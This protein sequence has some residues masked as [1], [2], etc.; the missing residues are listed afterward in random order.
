M[1]REA[2]VPGASHR[3]LTHCPNPLK[4]YKTFRESVHFSGERVPNPLNSPTQLRTTHKGVMLLPV[5]CQQELL[6]WSTLYPAGLLCGPVPMAASL[7]A[8]PWSQAPRADQGSPQVPEIQGGLSLLQDPAA[9]KVPWSH[10][11]QAH[12]ACQ[13]FPSPLPGPSALKVPG[14][15]A[16]TGSHSPALPSAVKSTSRCL[17]NLL[18]SSAPYLAPGVSLWTVHRILTGCP[19]SLPPKQSF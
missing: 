19:M 9:Q 10:S 1:G 2:R 7:P 15:P 3:Y 14:H 18:L 12:Q 11:C 17:G 8:L 4:W 5:E 6:K 13:L 16:R